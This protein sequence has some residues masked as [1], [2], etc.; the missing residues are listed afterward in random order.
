MRLASLSTNAIALL[1]TGQQPEP[2]R[3]DQRMKRLESQVRTL[4]KLALG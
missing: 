1:V 3:L 4:Q 2:N